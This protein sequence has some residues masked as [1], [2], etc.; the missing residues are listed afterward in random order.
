MAVNLNPARA[1]KSRWV[2]TEPDLPDRPRWYGGKI[3]VAEDNLLLGDVVCD[4]LRECG[5]DP[6]GPFATVEQALAVA[7]TA[8]LDGAV[9]DLKLGGNLCYPVC[10]ALQARGIPFV[11]LTG[12]VDLSMIP[13]ELTSTPLICKPFEA[14]EMKAAIAAM[15]QL[16]ERLYATA[17]H[18]SRH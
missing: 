8:A 2:R 10:T 18:A 13:P 16:D 11:F 6:C 12:Y 9:L 5:L 14:N 3:L 15:V 1:L 4:F 17:P 7:R